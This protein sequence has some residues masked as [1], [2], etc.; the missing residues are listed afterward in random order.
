MNVYYRDD[1]ILM[2]GMG[3]EEEV[4]H[5]REMF[6]KAIELDPRYAAAYAGLAATYH[7]D[8]KRG[9]S[10]SPENSGEK[11]IELAKKS[12]RTG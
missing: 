6:E 1:I 12:I 4:R 2:I 11:C 10:D 9:W 8:Y 7:E 3:P 5:A